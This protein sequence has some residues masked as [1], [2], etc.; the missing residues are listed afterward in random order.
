MSYRLGV[1]S[2]TYCNPNMVTIVVVICNYS[3]LDNNQ[4]CGKRLVWAN[5]IINYHFELAIVISVCLCDVVKYCLSVESVVYIKYCV[6]HYSSH[7]NS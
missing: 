2:V 7:S 3:Y 6:T 4:Q 1:S 5:E